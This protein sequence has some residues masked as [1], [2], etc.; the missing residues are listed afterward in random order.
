MFVLKFIL[1]LFIDSKTAIKQESFLQFYDYIKETICLAGKL[2]P[3]TRHLSRMK[4][5]IKKEGDQLKL[6]SAQEFQNNFKFT[7]S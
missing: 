4:T 1:L 3:G 2:F 6:V 7:F 5:N